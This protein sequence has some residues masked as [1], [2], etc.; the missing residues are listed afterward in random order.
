MRSP[1]NIINIIAPYIQKLRHMTQLMRSPQ[2]L[3]PLRYT[4][5]KAQDSTNEIPTKY[6]Q[7]HL[8]VIQKPRHRTQLMRSPQNIINIITPYIQKPR[9]VTQLMRSHKILS[10]SSLR[11]YKNWVYIISKYHVIFKIKN[12][13]VKYST[14]EWLQ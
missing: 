2:P 6:Y 1:Q 9:H 12:I 4:K 11:I 14:T 7:Y 8:S 5:T 3:L 13:N 10:I